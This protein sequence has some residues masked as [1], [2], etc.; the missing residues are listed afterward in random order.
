MQGLTIPVRQL[1]LRE[2]ILLNFYRKQIYTS[3]IILIQGI[4]LRILLNILL[5]FL[6][7]SETVL[8]V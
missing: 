2:D 5:Y 3:G 6:H 8:E 4:L 1:V 7:Y